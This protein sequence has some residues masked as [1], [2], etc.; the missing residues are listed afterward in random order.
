MPTDASGS[1]PRKPRPSRR[2]AWSL[3]SRQ[4]GTPHPRTLEN[5]TANLGQ[6]STV[7]VQRLSTSL[8]WF[9]GLRAD[10]RSEL[11]LLA[12]RGIASF[13]RWYENPQEPVWVLTEIFR[14]APTELTRSIT[15]QNALQVLRIVVDVV[16]EKVPELA[17]H[18]DE[19]AL[20]EAVLRFSREVAF[21]AADVYA[22]AAENRGSWDAR[23]ES[24]VVD[25]ILRGDHSD[26][27]RSRVSALGWTDEGD[28]TV[29]VGAAPETTGPAGVERI[30]RVVA[31]H[32]AECLVTIQ[33]DRLVLILGGLRDRERSL[34]RLAAVCGDGPVVHGPA[35]S[36][37]FEARHSADR[38]NAGLRAAWAWPQAPR[39]VCSEDLW[40]ERAVNGDPL[41]VQAMVE[42]VWQPLAASSTGLVDT[43]STYLGV[44][45]S[46][47]ATARE[48]FVHAN[49]V[50]YRLRRVSDITGWDPLL[51]RDAFVLHCA[52][53]A[54]RLHATE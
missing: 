12:Q 38:A 21:A 28:V 24:L 6:V 13:V 18:N 34:E 50:R 33:T 48:L 30:R 40:P 11:G 20:R 19:V 23:L 45:H 52:V 3:R 1:A 32:A 22:R 46:L 4:Q 35:V 14:Q 2:G 43:L 17:Q 41:A 7:A 42:A 26:S 10:E 36:S 47:E 5:L 44:G 25:G 37:V 53:L 54:G 16:E 29:M 9:E 31:R 49:T 27:L 39:P 15:L 8:P 51:P